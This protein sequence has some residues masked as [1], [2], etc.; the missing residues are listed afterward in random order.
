MHCSRNPTE[1]ELSLLHDSSLMAD[2]DCQDLLLDGQSTGI[3]GVP[4]EWIRD[5][6]VY[7]MMNRFSSLRPCT[8]PKDVLDMRPRWRGCSQLLDFGPP[9]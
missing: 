7:F 2:E 1:A 3:V 6:A 4:V 9:R 5:G 8:P